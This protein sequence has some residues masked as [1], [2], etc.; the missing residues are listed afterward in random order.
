[1]AEPIEPDDGMDEELEPYRKTVVEADQKSLD[2]YDKTVIT[3]ASGALALSLTLIKDLQPAH[4]R[5]ACLLFVAW[6]FLAATLL[7]VLASFLMSHLALRKTLDQLDAG[8]WNRGRKHPKVGGSLTIFV[9]VLNAAGGLSV[10][11]GITALLAFAGSNLGGMSGKQTDNGN[12]EE[13]TS[14]EARPGGRKPKGVPPDAPDQAEEVASAV[15]RDST[16]R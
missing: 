8:E 1:M 4:V 7:I 11:F 6:A 10:V 13:T 12:G 2:S 5:A 16:K 14:A 15:A 3:I 9:S